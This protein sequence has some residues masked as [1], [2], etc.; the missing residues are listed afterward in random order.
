MTLAITEAEARRILR[1]TPFTHS[2]HVRLLS[3]AEGECVL[4]V[5]FQEVFERP[6][7]LINGGVFMTTADVAMWL[8]IMTRIGFGERAVTS[9][10]QTSFLRGAS[11]VDVRCR[12]RILKLGRRLIYGIAECTGHE[13]QLLTHHTM[14]YVRL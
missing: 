3:L 11:K 5:P 9:D 1:E 13:G 7:G 10:M 12:A 6:D 2:Y 4:E 8:A 14:T